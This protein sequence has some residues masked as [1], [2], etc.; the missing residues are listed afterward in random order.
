M[1][2]DFLTI[3]FFMTTIF[4]FTLLCFAENDNELL[5][6]EN[7]ILSSQIEDYR[8]AYSKY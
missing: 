2:A 6:Q 3:L 7:K 4:A 1:K 5:Q 8:D